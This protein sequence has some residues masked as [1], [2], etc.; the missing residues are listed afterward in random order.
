MKRILGIFFKDVRRLWPR[1]AIVLVV[2]LLIGWVWL[3][4]PRGVANAWP[5][6][7]L[8][9]GLAWWYL[10]ASVIHEEAVPGDRQYWLTRPFSRWDL[11]AAKL[12]FILAFLSLPLFLGQV[13]SLLLRGVSPLAYL[14]DLLVCQLFYLAS[15][16]LPV[17]AWASVTA[18][19]VEFVAVSLAA[20][21]AYGVIISQAASHA[22]NDF[23]WG[24]LEWFRDTEGAAL[25]LAA[26][27]A[28]LA[29]QYFR[30]RTWFSRGIL[31]AAVLTSALL[32]WAPGW[33]SAFEL[34]TLLGRPVAG[35]V[36][37]MAFEPA[38]D[39]RTWLPI[40]TVWA[41]QDVDALAIPVQVAGIPGG[42]TLFSDR[43]GATI[44]TPGGERWSSDWDYLNALVRVVGSAHVA[45]HVER[46]LPGDGEYWLYLNIERS[47]YRKVKLRPMHLH[48]R[49]ALT[50][51][52]PERTT[53]L[54]LRQGAQA[55]PNDGFCWVTSSRQMLLTDCSWPVR[56]PARVLVRV[57]LRNGGSRQY[58]EPAMWGDSPGSYGAFPTSGGLWQRTV[59]SGMT[60]S[61]PAAVDLVTMEAV[62][63]FEREL[64]IPDLREWTNR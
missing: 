22:Q 58:G 11:L 44:E 64:D 35:S 6:L 16:A 61:P 40:K 30:R 52:S 14:A 24:G 3:A 7:S 41:G 12:I 13:A 15:A 37:R 63:H 43:A 36:A 53:P 32:K 39:P 29:L 54:A 18:G 4:A 27:G 5:A 26:A 8:L 48:A 51:L 2:E 46:L 62:A 47:F 28:V 59:L 56:T 20:W 31:A 19:L 38:R 50:L 10:I 42:L 17:A 33:P 34:Q 49:V 23:H 45:W 57:R 1:I 55:A 21:V 9:E 25:T 60:D